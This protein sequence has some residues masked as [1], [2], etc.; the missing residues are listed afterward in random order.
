MHWLAAAHALPSATFATHWLA[1]WLA[2]LGL[3][4]HGVLVLATPGSLQRRWW[5]H[6]SIMLFGLEAALLVLAFVFGS[7]G[8]RTAATTALVL[9]AAL[10]MLV[11][12]LGDWMQERKHWPR[13]VAVLAV[14]AL[15]ALAGLGVAGLVRLGPVTMLLTEPVKAPTLW[16]WLREHLPFGIDNKPTTGPHV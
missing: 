3:V 11:W 15:T 1:R 14:V 5:S 9:T 4:A 10:Q 12:V 7:D 8:L 13:L 2:R 6:A 16:Q